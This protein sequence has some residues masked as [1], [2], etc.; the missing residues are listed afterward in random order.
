[1]VLKKKDF[2]NRNMSISKNFE[3][4][5]KILLEYHAKLHYSYVL[6]CSTVKIKLNPSL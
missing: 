1:M 2:I 5:T 3:V 6:I 4:S